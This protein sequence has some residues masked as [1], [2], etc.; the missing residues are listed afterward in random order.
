MI[1]YTSSEITSL[2]TQPIDKATIERII[3]HIE[4]SQ[5]DILFDT[6][7]T[8]SNNASHRISSNALWLL[9]HGKSFIQSKLHHH[10]D[11]LI[12]QTIAEQDDTK[13]RLFTTIL[14]Q[15][16]FELQ[17]IRGDFVDFCMQSIT[18]S[19]VALAI[20]ANC[21]KLAYE[22]CRHFPELL[23]EL[24]ETFNHIQSEDFAPSIQASI[25]QCQIKAQKLLP[26]KR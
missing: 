22:Q 15:Q 4:T 5:D 14:L 1:G 18:Q 11:D 17:D 8:L 25:R 6:V 24:L 23:Q 13:C 10:Q 16:P 7:Y 26:K 3:V 12:T 20:R 2:L 21:I 19:S 9:S